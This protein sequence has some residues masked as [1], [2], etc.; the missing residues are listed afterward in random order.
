MLDF[1]ALY[2]QETC[3]AR[4]R[5]AARRPRSPKALF[6]LV[7]PGRAPLTLPRDAVV[8]RVTPPILGGEG[9]MGAGSVPTKTAVGAAD[10]AGTLT[11]ALIPLNGYPE[12][13]PADR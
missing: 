1:G 4:P 2:W 7:E 12:V 5:G 6:T 8:I 3:P 9:N 13:A 11:R 10:G